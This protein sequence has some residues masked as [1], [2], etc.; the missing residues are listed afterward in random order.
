MTAVMSA[1]SVSDFQNANA[2]YGSGQYD[3]A[4]ASYE[5]LLAQGLHSKE[6]HYNL[7]QAHYKQGQLGKAILHLEKAAKLA[8]GDKKIADDLSIAYADVEV[9]VLE[10]PDFLLVRLWKGMHSLLSAN[11]WVIVQWLL[12]LILLVGIYLWRLSQSSPSRVRGFM[13]MLCAIPLLMLSYFLG[14]SQHTTETSSVTAIVME[15]TVLGDTPSDD[16]QVLED[17]SPGVKVKILDRVEEWYKVSLINKAQG[18]VKVDALEK[19]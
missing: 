9:E 5:A 2:A 13:M 18:W 8:P 6:L 14:R 1:Q 4:I 19:I 16:P 17:L 11:G 12:V 3:K 10:V 7:G 15:S